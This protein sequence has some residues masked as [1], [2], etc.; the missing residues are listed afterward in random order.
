MTTR[1]PFLLT[2]TAL[3]LTACA[4]ALGGP[5]QAGPART[6]TGHVQVQP[7]ACVLVAQARVG[8]GT[9]LEARLQ[10]REALAA[11]YDLRVRGPGV[12]IDQGGDLSLAAG[13]SAVLGE[14]NVSTAASAIDA[15]LTVTAEGRT[16]TCP[17]RG[18]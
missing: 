7:F 9:R 10:A 16:V 11:S 14:A 1:A 2:V 8:G 17:I 3:V 5:Y 12:F 13:E 18:S 15:R 4:M 6:I